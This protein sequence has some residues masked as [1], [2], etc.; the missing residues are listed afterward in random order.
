MNALGEVS[1]PISFENNIQGF[2][3]LISNIDSFVKKGVVFSFESTTH[4]YKVLEHFLNSKGYTTKLMNPLEVI[5][6]RK[7]NIRNTKNGKVDAQAICL[8]LSDSQE[9]SQQ[10]SKHNDFY[11][12]CLSRHDLLTPKSRCKIK[13]ASYL[14]IVFLELT[15]YFKGNLSI[16]AYYQRLKIY[17]S[18]M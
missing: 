8:S 13:F 5:P 15:K 11:N 7:A 3:K 6:F 16:N 9:K 18:S 1:Q 12:L 17:P 2:S 10:P 4:Y 14:D